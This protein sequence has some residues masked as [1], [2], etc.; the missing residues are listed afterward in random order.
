MLSAGSLDPTFGTGG[1]VTTAAIAAQLPGGQATANAEVV[2][3]DGKVIIAGT[4]GQVPT[5]YFLAR[6]DVDGSL[7]STFGSGGIVLAQSALASSISA[8]A[9]QSDGKIVAAG[10]KDVYRFN[11]NGSLDTSFGSAGV[12]TVTF[13]VTAL[14]VNAT[15]ETIAGGSL[16]SADDLDLAMFTSA[17]A[18]I[19]PLATEASSHT[20]TA[21]M[22]SA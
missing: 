9:I 12:A 16:Y 17:G 1:I 8:I 15:G 13:N 20:T 21:T 18:L 6:Y 10:G 3:P 7:D 22:R 19:P 5:A 11:S 4:A 2:Q 14:A